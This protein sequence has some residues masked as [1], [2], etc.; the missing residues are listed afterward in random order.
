MKSQVI[1]L[2]GHLLPS[3]RKK[4]RR[5]M[6][7]DLHNAHI[8]VRNLGHYV[9]DNLLELN[10]GTISKIDMFKAISGDT[11]FNELRIN[12]LLSDLQEVVMKFL[13]F[14][15]KGG[16][17]Y[18]SLLRQG[19][20][21]ADRKAMRFVGKTLRK[22]ERLELS[23][24]E[25]SYQALYQKEQKLHLE[26]VLHL[27]NKPH[28]YSPALQ[29]QMDTLDEYYLVKKLRLACEM[30][31][32]S[33]L[34]KE[35]Y[36]IRFLNNLIP[37]IELT[38]QSNPCI[39]TYYLCLKMLSNRKE[40]EFEALIAE[41]KISSSFFPEEEL[42]VLYGYLINFGIDK[43]N[44]GNSLYY[45]K[46]FS[47]YETMIKSR[48]IFFNDYISEWT[49]KNIVTTGIRIKKYDW[50]KDFIE[51]YKSNLQ[52]KDFDNAVAYNLASLYFAEEDYSASLQALLGVEFTDAT[53]FIGA[54]II[55]LKSYYVLM[56]TEAFFSLIDSFK[57]YIS[58]NKKLSAN[59]ILSNQNFLIL[60]K[61][62]YKLK[63]TKKIITK[64]S[65]DQKY[66]DFGKK[67]GSISPL[68]NK[69]W[70]KTCYEEL[71]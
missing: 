2:I 11:S 22:M 36:T 27:S 43:I 17:K 18:G 28:D 61:R 31:N 46:I 68:A 49:F 71:H 51:T 1:E 59:K 34:I 53:Y 30:Q 29:H 20:E 44:S 48:L 63:N 56:E 37:L 62:L 40:D 6:N 24:S 15:K 67:L 45:Q 33:R 19:F 21:L 16:E 42:R 50:T 39:S 52:Q 66:K 60:A 58:R 70:I 54:K 41:L 10:N 47:I 5:W 64:K 7:N 38:E 8:K 12:N 65:W 13:V 14:L 9:L 23:N 4:L 3:E 35:K 32:R 26:D 57:K 25:H 69:D 55:Q